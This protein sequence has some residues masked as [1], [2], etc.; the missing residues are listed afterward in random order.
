MSLLFFLHIF[1]SYHVQ[2]NTLLLH[3]SAHIS[4]NNMHKAAEIM[5][6]NQI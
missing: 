3:L 4:A 5:E 6:F 1:M 2:K